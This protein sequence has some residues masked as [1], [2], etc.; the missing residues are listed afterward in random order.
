MVTLGSE[1][2]IEAVSEVPTLIHLAEAIQAPR[3]QG[4]VLPKI[5]KGHPAT[6]PRYTDNHLKKKKSRQNLQ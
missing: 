4:L 2:P 6:N 1:P 3:S 5:P